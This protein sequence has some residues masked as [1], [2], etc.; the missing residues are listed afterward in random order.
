MCN[1][2]DLQLVGGLEEGAGRVEICIGGRWGT[3]CDD[4]GD[5]VDAGVICY[6]LG[7]LREGEVCV[8]LEL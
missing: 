8:V 1:H 6:Q 7:Y 3:I 2:G 5:S 4:L